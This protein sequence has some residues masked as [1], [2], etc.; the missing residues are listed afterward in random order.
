MNLNEILNARGISLD[1][2]MKKQEKQKI[3]E[4]GIYQI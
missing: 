3:K 2:L 1:E 4:S